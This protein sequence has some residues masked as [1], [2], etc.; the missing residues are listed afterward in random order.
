MNSNKIFENIGEKVAIIG[1][2]IGNQKHLSAI[3]DGFASFIPFIIVGSFAILI[4]SVIVDGNSL[5]ATWTGANGSAGWMKFSFYVSPV[6][7]GITDATMSF[8][9]IYI[10]FLFGYFLSGSYGDNKIAGAG[11]GLACFLVLQPVAAG[12]ASSIVWNSPTGFFGSTG[13]LFAMIGGLGGPTIFHHLASNGKFSVHMPDGVPPA[14]SNSFAVLFPVIFTVLIFGL[15]QPIWGAFA[16]GVGFGK[17]EI[18]G[19]FSFGINVQFDYLLEENGEVFEGISTLNINEGSQFYY[20]VGQ[21]NTFYNYFDLGTLN[22][23][24]DIWET[25]VVIEGESI[26][27]WQYL[28]NE[29]TNQLLANNPTYF[30][31]ENVLLVN[32]DEL[33]SKDN[34]INLDYSFI[35]GVG[36]LVVIQGASTYVVNGEWYYVIN[37]VNTILVLPVQNAADTAGFV[38]I[39][40][41]LVGFFWFFGIHG[42]NILAPVISLIWTTAGLHNVEVLAAFNGDV[43]A[44]IAS[45]LLF[46][47]TDQTENAFLM[48]G[49]AGA[50]L[51]LL[52]AIFIF[53]KSPQH[54]AIANVAAPSGIFQ[55]NEPVLFGLPIILNPLWAIPFMFVMPIA[56]VFVFLI[57]AAGWLNPTTILL[58]WTT[59]IFISGFLSTQDWRSFIWT[60]VVFFFVFCS[61]LPFVLLDV[62]KQARAEL[63]SGEFKDYDDLKLKIKEIKMKIDI[64][65][66]QG[67]EIKNLDKMSEEFNVLNIKK[68]NFENKFIDFMNIQ[69]H[70]KKGFE[71]YKVSKDL[72]D[73]K[74]DLILTNKLQSKENKHNPIISENKKRIKTI[75]TELKSL[76]KQQKLLNKSVRVNEKSDNLILMKERKNTIKIDNL[77]QKV[78]RLNEKVGSDDKI[79]ILNRKIKALKNNFVDYSAVKKTKAKEKYDVLIEKA[80]IVEA[81]RK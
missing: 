60:A 55:I 79:L 27:L 51:A 5:L 2:K 59:P 67:K 62:R 49:G 37:A 38:F 35:E 4:N 48:M 54:R 68:K 32:M 43:N 28:Q 17:T 81:K 80:K 22:I 24:S 72:V 7:I 47:F 10:A 75:N 63:N 64:S 8:F 18:V 26:P 58:P 31:I 76:V 61:Y 52:T 34:F 41:F 46:T 6:F 66:E 3:R 57:T 25:T 40:M 78:S 50:T 73:E 14:V 23:E 44:A 30:S 70:V 15:I 77:N 65:E 11:I 1:Q 36:T 20:V 74:F 9:S 71:N 42:N 12:S 53:S 29:V 13:I 33:A 69:I 56:G 16:Y 45:G 19:T 39:L 21:Y